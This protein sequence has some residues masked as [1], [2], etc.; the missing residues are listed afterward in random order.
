MFKNASWLV[1]NLTCFCS[2]L[3]LA[4]VITF[5]VYLGIYAFDNPEPECYYIAGTETTQPQL[6]RI[7]DV[8]SDGVEP[9]HDEFVKWFMWM[10][11][12]QM[13]FIGL[14]CI[15][16]ALVMLMAKSPTIG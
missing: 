6:K 12:N 11:V 9:I 5:C 13:V 2:F 3:S 16:P 4:A 8:N 15:A 10:F 1:Q 14:I 7:A